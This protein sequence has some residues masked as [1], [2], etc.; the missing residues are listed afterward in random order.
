MTFE[1]YLD[2][3]RAR[4]AR[5]RPH[6]TPHEVRY[7]LGEIS[8]PEHVA[9]WAGR[10]PD[11]PAIVFAD[12][13][14]GYRELDELS[15]RLAG[16][17]ASVG[18]K[19]GDRVAVHLPNCPQFV[20]A[21]LA[22]LRL[23][24][25]H[26]PVNPMFQA[27]ELAHELE[28]CGATAA[29]TLD[30]LV[31]LL[32]AARP[33]TAV[34]T[35]LVTSAAE[36]SGA[37]T[38]PA[39]AREGTVRCWEQALA[40]E[41][42]KDAPTDLD[43][44]AALNYTGGTTGLP[45]GCMHTQRH[46]LYTAAS[47][48]GATG[49]AADRGYVALCYIPVFW[50]A[51]EDLGILTPLVLGGTS[52]LM[53]RWDPAEV[54]RAIDTHRVTTMV[55]TVENYLELTELLSRPEFSAYDLSSLTDPMAVSF[56]RKLDPEVRG[57][58]AAVAGPGSLLREGA[59]GM[60]ETHT[61]DATPYGLAENDED[62]TTEPVFCGIPVPGTDIA[63]VSFGTGEPL[64]LGEAGEIIVRS[65][66]VMTGYW[67]RPEATAEQLRDGW[68]HT[69]DNGRIDEKGCLHYLGRDKDMI[70]VKGMSV[71]PAEVEMLLC[72]HPDVH[73]AAVVPAEDAARGQTPV[74]FVQLRPGATTD[75]ATL[76]AWA[77]E[78]MAPYKVPL[79]ELV[80]EFPMTTT[81]KI[82]KVELADRAQS[83]ATRA[84]D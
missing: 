8:L 20:I 24:A 61:F 59:Y 6:D 73:T 30:T 44:L 43:A 55:G 34:Q 66:S 19:A 49:H 51:G 41:R 37:P 29:I 47:S 3:L 72:R 79:L 32:E 77:A 46:M 33:S 57:R 56:V 69:G 53:S 26:V 70:K 81:G 48:A 38:A 12:R 36:M 64:P 2:D 7:P 68:L 58:W 78:N 74:A 23:G 52:V 63:V 31:P 39:V 60:T 80:P 1:E 15:G 5:V 84:A 9:H 18:V 45:K 14:V 83:L 11:R 35:V 22:A 17:L 71:F 82:R 25:V 50:I 10:Y 27:A 67:R 13:T 76:R 65:P 28:D 54:L 62:L 21:M 42:A 40:H 16:W 75:A 4:Q